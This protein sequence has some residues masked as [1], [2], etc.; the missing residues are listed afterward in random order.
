MN[1]NQEND[2]KALDELFIE[3]GTYR[4]RKDF[5]QLLEFV[6]RFKYLAPYNAFLVHIQKPGSLYV[7]TASEW[8]VKFKRKIIPG[9]RPL[10]ILRPFGPVSF[11]FELGDTYGGEAFPEELLHPFKTEGEL[12]VTKFNTLLSNLICDGISYHRENYGVSL[13]GSIQVADGNMNIRIDRKEVKV[14]YNMVV[15]NNSTK[16]EQ[17]ATIAHE[18][19][20]L[21]CGH[22]GTPNKKWWPDFHAKNKQSKEFEAESV[23]WIVC[24]RNNVKN[25]SAAYLNGYLDTN[26][27]IPPVSLENILKASG[28]IERKMMLRQSIR[29]ELIVKDFSKIVT[30][31]TFGTYGGSKLDM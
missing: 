26:G 5:K 8:K 14:L 21:Y 30:Q 1:I 31:L 18:L 3:A 9:A 27:D 20:H 11:V 15:N 28:M 10:V 22:L 2:I 29:K 4:N 23:A 7:A 6:K 19:G 25:P 13:A 24:E 12:E 17:F 16:E